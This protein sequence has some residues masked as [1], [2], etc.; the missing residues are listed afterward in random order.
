MHENRETSEAL[1]A[2]PSC[3][4]VDE[5]QSHK[6]RMY[7]SEESH[8]GIVPMNPSNKDKALLAEKG[9]GRLP[10]KENVRPP[11]TH[12]T[13]SGER[14][15]QGLAGVRKAA[16]ENKEMKFTAL[17]HHLT[18]ELLRKSF[19]SLKRKAASG[20]DGVTWQE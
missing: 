4:S 12:P 3:R 16:R 1:A 9:E 13:Q 11:N 17:L 20:A 14:V 19:Y 5:G 10:I 18:I 8:G 2:Q 7:V 6:V 15:S